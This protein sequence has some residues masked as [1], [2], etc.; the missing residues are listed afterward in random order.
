MSKLR[1]LLLLVGLMMTAPAGVSQVNTAKP[2]EPVERH[3]S[4]DQTFREWSHDSNSTDKTKLIKVC[5][6]EN[7]C[8]MRYREGQTPRTRVRK[9]VAPLRYEDENTP[10]SDAFT[11]QV[12]QALDNLGDKR[13]VTVRFIG[14][15]DDAPLTGLDE[16]TYGNHLSVSKARAHRVALEMQKILRLP[17]S[18]IESDGRGASHPLASNETPQGRTLNRRIEVEFWYDDPLQELSDEPQLCPDDTEE[19]VTRVYDPPWGSIPSLELE[20]GQP[21][22]PPGY[23][24][25]LHRALTEIADRTNVRLRFIGYTKNE[26]LDRR[27]ASV[28]GDDIGLSAARARRAMNALMQDP[29][30]SGARSEHE[31]RGYVQSD[32]VVNSGFTQGQDSFVRVQ[33]V[34]D[35]RLPLDNYEGVDITRLTQEVRPKS[36]YELNVM[37]I[38]VDGKPI[39]D[40][41][42]S[43][44]D[45]QRCTDVALDNAK[46]HFRFDNLEGRRRLGVAANPVAV[47]VSDLGGGPASSVVHFRMYS[48][49]ASFLKRSEIRIFEQQQSLE[50]AP[51]KIIAVDDAGLAEWHPTVEIL[52]GPARELKYL[53][54][55]YDSKGNFDETDA[56]PLRLY[57]EPSPGN[58]AASDGPPARE[59]LAAYGENDLKRQQIPLGSGTVKVQGGGIPAGHTVWLAGRQIPVDAQGN[60][61]AEEILPAGAH[62]VEVAV[63]DDA[64][65]GSLYLRDLEFKRTDLFYVGIAD[66]T[67]SKNSA[68]APAKLQE[69]EN[70]PQPYNSSLDGRLAFYL[71]GNVHENWRLTASADTREGPVKDL[72][73]NFL[74]KSPDSL[75]RRIDPD[76][77]YPSFGD[78]GAVQEMAP[79]MGKFYVKASNGEN[80]GMWGNFKIGYLDNELAHVDRGLYGA[81]AHYA[82]EP[83]TSFG[84]RRL[85]V[86]GFAAQPGTMAS[87]EE[88][89]GT[90]GSLYFLHHQDILT[91]SERVRIEIRDKASDIVTGVVNLQP[92][93]DYDIDYL[94]GRVLLSQ[95]L[96]STAGDNLLVRTSGLSGDEA[97]LVV[98]YEYTPGFQTLNEVAVGG[99]AHYWFNDYVRLGLTADSNEGDSASNLGAADLTLRKSANS[100]FKLQA[101][102]STGLLS[103]S[104][105]SNDGGFGF[106]GPADQSFTG[107]KAGAYR[108]DLSVGMSDFFEGRDGRLTF[109][110]QHLDAG[111]SA[112]GEATIKDTDQYGGTFRMPVTSS[113]SLAAKG[114]QKIENQ[115]LETRAVEVDVA[116]KVAEKWTVSSGVRNDLR[117]DHSPVVP[118][119][120]I[121]GERTDAVAQV[122]FDSS[123]SWS[124]YGF[125]QRT[126]AASGGRED[127]DRIGVGGSYRLTKRF[128][129][130]GE[131]S[132]GHLGPGGKVG[133]SFLDSQ[134]TSYYLNYSLENERTDNGLLLRGSQGNLVLGTKVRLSDTSS[135]YVEERYENGGS[136]SG[137]THT[138]GINLTT[139]EHWNLGGSGEVG[140]LLD[141]QT[142]AETD[143]KAARINMGYGL[144]KMQFS[145]AIEFRRD[146]GEQLDRTHNEMTTWL[147]R[148]NFKLQLTPDWRLIGKLDHSVSDSSLGDF[149][150]GGY[151][152]AVVGYAYRPV[153]ND[154]LNA[155][156]KY[157]YF[158]NVPTTGQVGLQNTAAEFLQK[159]HIA[160]LDLNYDL[161]ANWSLGG[162]YAYRMGQESLDRVHPNFFDNAGQLSVLRV[163]WRFLKEWDGLAEVR[164]LYLPDISQRRRGAL[165]AIYRHISKNLKAGVGYNF[166]DFSDDL[167]DLKYNHKGVFVNLIGTM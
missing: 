93:V 91:G 35:E 132:D 82:A 103:P 99:Q 72:F 85:T 23:A 109:Y 122:K 80:Y 81:N 52:A 167:T 22:I 45:I 3:L 48:N 104:L 142:G 17:A 5:R 76:Y 30:L 44:S 131:A 96:S 4:S 144:A 148:N 66:L 129:I 38:T 135:V 32:D 102:R 100:W 88:F 161:T 151:T 83:T 62:S 152:E 41:G 94:Q 59:L 51:L 43:S 114:D 146:N 110:K 6:A 101:G 26:R 164:T 49:Y 65:N 15:T 127:N 165:A 12:R 115:G 112:P 13:G 25:N 166:T 128:R 106:Q 10:I 58:V 124:A 150:A 46:I 113:L 141:S 56:R 121:Q 19:T 140:K 147:F 18:A 123:A 53:L 105:Q 130:D 69:G 70:D 57:R 29:V 42:R 145:S 108:A 92:N 21:I 33:V 95:P 9:L 133:T 7:V 97:Y 64:G 50:A 107:A 117:E 89:R 73:S 63:L 136:L 119:T 159:S 98:R 160:A 79:T 153:R 61:A 75:F 154:R 162:K 27:T 87:Y 163:D 138:T 14:Y 137:L 86:D 118:A 84:E 143:R 47:A 36:P 60:F 54:R 77:Y 24:A 78:D 74:A 125:G 134:G 111:Y 11:S 126:V 20:N 28:Y 40:P 1:H 120:Q 67:V 55:A 156:V 34:Y 31:G 68:S 139:K 16:S 71:N 2:G 157:T 37:R 8:K 116:Y 155:L 158:Y 149:Y 39:D 90:G